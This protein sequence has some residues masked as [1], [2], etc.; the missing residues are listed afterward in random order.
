MWKID[1]QLCMMKGFG[2]S[3]QVAVSGQ[4][5]I[6]GY[7]IWRIYNSSQQIN[8]ASVCLYDNMLQSTISLKPHDSHYL[9]AFDPIF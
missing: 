9:V 2:V 8:K 4:I 1:A 6:L 3:K 7:F 5:S